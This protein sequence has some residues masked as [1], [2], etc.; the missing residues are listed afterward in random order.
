MALTISHMVHCRRKLSKRLLGKLF[1]F[2]CSMKTEVLLGKSWETKL[3]SDDVTDCDADSHYEESKQGHGFMQHHCRRGK[4]NHIN[5]NTISQAKS[6]KQ[7]K[8]KY[9]K[10]LNSKLSERLRKRPFKLSVNCT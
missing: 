10:Q 4:N 5:D 9:Q 1:I 8:T 7:N 2:T 3:K 6:K